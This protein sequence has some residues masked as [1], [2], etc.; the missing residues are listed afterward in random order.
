MTV[1][2]YD[3]EWEQGSDRPGYVSRFRSI[4]A[5]L[6]AER[7]GATLYGLESGERICPYHLHYAEEEWLLVV[8]GAPTLRTPDGVRALRPGDVVAFPRGPRGAHEVRNETPEPVRV[9]ML[10][11]KEDVDVAVFPDSGKVAAT[12]NRLGAGERVRIMNRPE[13]NLDYFDGEA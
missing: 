4:G 9:L 5:A 8:E 3:D 2:V 7:L 6:G 11:T 10:S 12:A 13:A 1:N